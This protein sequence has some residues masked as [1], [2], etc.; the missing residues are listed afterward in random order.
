MRILVQLLAVIFLLSSG[1]ACLAD[2]IA[3]PERSLSAPTNG[4]ARPKAMNQ[5]DSH[6]L[7]EMMDKRDWDHR[8][9]G[10]DWRLRG[11]KENLGH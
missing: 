9:A 2:E 11:N 6:R 4:E 8:K 10:R 5:K 1:A 3:K 7:Q